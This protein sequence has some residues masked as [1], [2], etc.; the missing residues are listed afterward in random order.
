MNSAE[1]ILSALRQLPGLDELGT[2]AD[3]GD[4]IEVNTWDRTQTEAVLGLLLRFYLAPA[5]DRVAVKNSVHRC[6]VLLLLNSAHPLSGEVFTPLL[7]VLKRSQEIKT[8]CPALNLLAHSFDPQFE[9]WFQRFAQHSEPLIADCAKR[10]LKLL[11]SRVG[12]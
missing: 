3:L 12:M 6:L 8:I 2:L 10:S 11:N 1:Q 7:Q 4:L 5:D 9:P